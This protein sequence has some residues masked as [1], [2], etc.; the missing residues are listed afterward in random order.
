MK[1]NYQGKYM[2]RPLILSIALTGV[3]HFS[4]ANAAGQGLLDIYNKAVEKDPVLAGAQFAADAGKEKSTQ[5]LSLLLPR[6]SVSAD[7]SYDYSNIQYGNNLFNLPDSK[8]L[9][10]SRSYGMQVSQPLFRAADIKAYSQSK[11][12]TLQ[13]EIQLKI[14]EQ[15]L[16]LRVSQAYFDVLSANENL[17]VSN[18]QSKAFKES[19]ERAKLT[20]KV[21]TSTKTDK[22]EAQARYDLAKANEISASN[23]LAI[24]KQSLVSI[25][26]EIPST[27]KKL[28]DNA[29]LTKLKANNIQYWVDT[30]IARN[31]QL[32]LVNTGYKISKFE[33]QKLKSDRLPTLDLVASASKSNRYNSF[34]DKNIDTTNASIN[35]QL[36]MPI[37]TGGLVSSRI[38]EAESL[39]FQ[40]QQN[41]INI[42]RQIVLQ[43]QRAYLNSYN[44]LQ[45]VEALQQAL[46][47]SNSA[48]EATQKGLEVGVRTNLDLLDS[49]QQF[50]STERDFTIAKYNY[51]LNVLNLKAAAGIL[52]QDDIADMDSLLN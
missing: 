7:A 10:D 14:A 49:Q 36:A 9:S 40:Q 16:I 17:Q 38:R 22:L 19:L 4:L 29:A 43:A 30:A 2:K 26:G 1:S 44:G 21:G 23:Q 5:G 28:K 27:L 12:V 47:S 45:Q 33:V 20:F 32:G 52:S 46:K 25:I 11:I 41:K 34:L 13:T 35:L 39:K 51:L 24:A 15:D 31:L 6:V 8:T 42:Q 50:F 37:Y 48:L 18:S 3:M